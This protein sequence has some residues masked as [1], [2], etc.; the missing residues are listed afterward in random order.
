MRISLTEKVYKQLK[1]EIIR[2]DLKENTFMTESEFS[3]RFKVS[4]TPVREAFS[5]LISEGFIEALPHKGY[6]ITTLSVKDLHNLFQVRTI[7]ELGAIKLVIELGTEEEITE[8]GKVSRMK[9]EE[10]EEKESDDFHGYS[11]INQLFHVQIAKSTHNP[12]LEKMLIDTLNQLARPLYKDLVRSYDMEEMYETHNKIYQAIL[13]RDLVLAYK[14][15]NDHIS[16]SKSRIF[17]S[18]K[19]TI[20]GI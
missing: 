12:Y 13:T 14:L 3:N 19:N 11:K 1:Y 5:L 7:L 16:K 17:N 6:V 8:I 10:L 2:G 20:N 9:L 4:K 18:D 15:V